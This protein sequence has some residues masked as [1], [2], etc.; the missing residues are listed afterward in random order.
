MDLLLSQ[1]NTGQLAWAFGVTLA[2]AY[3]HGLLGL[4]FVSV[5]MPLLVLFIDLRTAMVVTVPPA[6]FLSARLAFFGG[7][8]KQSLGRHWFMPVFMMIGGV[9]GA[10]LF[11][12][13]PQQAL[14]MIIVL[15]L[16]LFLS[17]DTLK[18]SHVHLPKPWVMPAAA[19][20][21]FLAGNTETSINMGAPFL[22]VFFLIAG[23]A[24]N[25]I[26]QVINLC[27][28]SGKVVHVITLSIGG[29]A[30]AAVTLPEW[31][32]GLI[33]APVCIWLCNFGVRKRE[34]TPVETYRR[35]LKGFLSA[36]VV[37]LLGKLALG[38]WPM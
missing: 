15:V 17:I 20:F 7:G 34:R 24:P 16:I 11:Q 23:Y 10:W 25:L 31:I 8:L 4:G 33:M 35:W 32:P 21:A 13:L 27:F 28:F 12:T 3:F 26:V 22:L 19:F 38:L 9:S 2:A 30:N 18:K 5:A 29:A 1:I 14:L 6:F 37:V 36:L